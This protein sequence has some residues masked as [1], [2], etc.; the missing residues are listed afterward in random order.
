MIHSLFFI[1]F[2]LAVEF[3]NQS[4]YGSIHIFMNRI[5][6]C[7]TPTDVNSG[8]GLLAQLLHREDYMHIAYIIEVPLQALKLASNI[9]T[10][11]RSDFDMMAGYVQLHF[12][13]PSLL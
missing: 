2:Y 6:E 1:F 8:F 7:V 11:G 13:A 3:V 4:V 5:S 9:V 12:L 10:K